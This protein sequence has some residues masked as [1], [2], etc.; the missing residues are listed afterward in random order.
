MN[1]RVLG[2]RP[3][4]TTI[5]EIFS[6]VVG[7]GAQPIV[8]VQRQQIPYWQDRGWSRK[9]QVYSGSY[10]TP[11]GAFC[12]RIEQRG[13][14]SFEFF[15]YQPSEEIKSHSH[16]VCFQDRRNG[17]YLVHMGREPKDVSSGIL[18]IERLITEA[19]E[20]A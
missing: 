13:L 14:A 17:W 20:G 11:Y 7:R 10:Q 12:G 4:S 6:R 8:T 16:W 3:A 9:G 19:Y 1:V 18:T 15:L 5:R 2:V